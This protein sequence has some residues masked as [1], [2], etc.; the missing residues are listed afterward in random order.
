MNALQLIDRYGVNPRRLWL[1]LIAQGYM[2]R[3][4]SKLLAAGAK[5][6]VHEGEKSP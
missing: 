5:C 1:K 2:C 6:P 4:C 3:E